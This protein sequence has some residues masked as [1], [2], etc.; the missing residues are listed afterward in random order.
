[1][2]EGHR[3]T[4]MTLEALDDIQETNLTR[5]MA[6]EQNINM[7]AWDRKATKVVTGYSRI[8]ASRVK[9]SK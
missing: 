3:V 1:M 6:E 2:F 7:D 4:S 5:P 8:L 9:N